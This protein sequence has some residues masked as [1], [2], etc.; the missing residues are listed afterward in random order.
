MAR[1]LSGSL[2]GSLPHSQA[3]NEHLLWRLAPW[4]VGSSLRLLCFC[5]DLPQGNLCL[6]P[7]KNATSII[8]IKV[9]GKLLTA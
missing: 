3:L 2:N 5:H 1:V 7:I 4:L 8:D 6:L 9:I